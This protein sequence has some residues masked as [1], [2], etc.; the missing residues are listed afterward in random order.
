MDWHQ[1]VVYGSCLVL[2][3]VSNQGPPRPRR[4]FA[5]P[6]NTKSETTAGGVIAPRLSPS[7]FSSLGPRL[8]VPA[9][10]D[11]AIAGEEEATFLS[12][13][14]WQESATVRAFSDEAPAIR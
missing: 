8:E 3:E 1:V 7:G 12:D 6:R 10:G 2:Q 5:H 9:D 13:G 14:G 11:A 4:T